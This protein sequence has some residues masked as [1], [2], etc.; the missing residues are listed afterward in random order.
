MVSKYSLK[1]N[2]MA[3]LQNKDEGYVKLVAE[4]KTGV[5]VG[6]EL[7]CPEAVEIASLCK[8][9]IDKKKTK[10]GYEIPMTRYFYEFPEVISENDIQEKLEMMEKNIQE[11]LKSLFSEEL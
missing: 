3:V 7:V 6:V 9:W 11:S 4:K 1:G 8:G 5:L 2:G 10:I